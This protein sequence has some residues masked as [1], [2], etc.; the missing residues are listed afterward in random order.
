MDEELG[1]T[2]QVT[3]NEQVSND[4]QERRFQA[5]IDDPVRQWKLSTMDLPARTQWFDY[6]R[7]R[8]TMLKA[9][10]TDETPWYI[11]PSDDKK[12]ARLNCIAHFL[13]MIPY[14][15]V[16]KDRVK[17]PKRSLKDAYD[18]QATLVGRRFVPALY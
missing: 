6:S 3:K 5:R 8:D 2:E 15:N 16:R 12:R 13:G 7:A 18:D 17:M 14:K 4:E 1:E 11:V 9:T 10:D